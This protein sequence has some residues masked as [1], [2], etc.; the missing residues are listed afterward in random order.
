MIGSDHDL[1]NIRIEIS[2][3]VKVSHKT[4]VIWRDRKRKKL[5]RGLSVEGVI[6]EKFKNWCLKYENFDIERKCTIG[7]WAILWQDSEIE[8]AANFFLNCYNNSWK[9]CYERVK[10]VV[11]SNCNSKMSQ[12]EIEVEKARAKTSK[13]IAARVVNCIDRDLES[14]IVSSVAERD[15]L[16]SK[17][18]FDKMEKDFKYQEHSYK[19]NPKLFYSAISMLMNKDTYKSSLNSYKS[20]EEEVSLFEC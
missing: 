2:D 8:N 12:D 4:K 18:I 1:I 19:N 3:F 13:L 20:E 11:P 6:S 9:A 15:K 16:I 14:K 5:P 7:D 10:C 17:V